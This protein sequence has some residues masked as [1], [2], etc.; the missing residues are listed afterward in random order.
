MRSSVVTKS[1]GLTA[2]LLL[3]AAI[4][5]SAQSRSTLPAGTVITVKTTTPLQST[6]AKQ[7]DIFETVIEEDVVADQMVVIPAGSRV[8]G[9]VALATKATRQES[10]VID[11]VFD[12]LLHADGT[13]Y[14]IQGKLTSADTAERRQI[15]ANPNQRVVLVG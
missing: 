14:A 15:D 6:T 3:S 4:A 2:A 7:G 10:G 8:R 12:R 13:T 9:V 11:I 5:I 1:A